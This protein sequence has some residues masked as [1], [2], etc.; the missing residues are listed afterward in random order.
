MGILELP[1]SEHR[2]FHRFSVEGI[3]ACLEAPGD[4][5]VTS[6]S[7]TGLTFETSAELMENCYYPLLLEY[8]GHRAKVIV[9]IKWVKPFSEGSEKSSSPTFRV[10]ASFFDIQPGSDPG[11]WKAL[12]SDD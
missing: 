11:L 2:R 10:G 4:V 8:R 5:S 6:I 9:D 3:T 1:F 7:Q 12:H